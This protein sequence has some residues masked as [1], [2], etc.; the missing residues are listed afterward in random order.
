MRYSKEELEQW[1]KVES[2]FMAD[3]LLSTSRLDTFLKKQIQ[4][5]GSSKMPEEDQLY[6]LGSILKRARGIHAQDAF[7]KMYSE[8]RINRPYL[9]ELIRDIAEVEPHTIDHWLRPL[10][11]NNR[12]TLKL[13]ILS[14]FNQYVKPEALPN[15]VCPVLLEKPKSLYK[16]F[17]AR[18]DEYDDLLRTAKTLKE[19][20]PKYN[21]LSDSIIRSV[22]F[23]CYDYGNRDY[24][25]TS[26][27]N[28]IMMFDLSIEHDISIN[29]KQ[30]LTDLHK[31]YKPEYVYPDALAYPIHV[32]SKENVTEKELKL[33]FDI[34][35]FILEV[36][37]NTTNESQLYR[38]GLAALYGLMQD[39][40]QY[41]KYITEIERCLHLQMKDKA[42]GL[43]NLKSI[44]DNAPSLE[45]A[46]LDTYQ[47]YVG[48]VHNIKLIN[49]V[50]YCQQP[51]APG[52]E[53]YGSLVYTGYNEHAPALVKAY[54]QPA[55]YIHALDHNVQTLYI[56]HKEY[57]DSLLS[58]LTTT[59][60]A[61]A[62]EPWSSDVFSLLKQSKAL[63]KLTLLFLCAGVTGTM[64]QFES[65]REGV[66]PNI[67]WRPLPFLRTMYPEHLDAWND[68][69]QEIMSVD[70]PTSSD[71]KKAYA[72]MFDYLAP[73]LLSNPPP[74]TQLINISE[75]L[76]LPIAEYV[77][78]LC[79]TQD[80]KEA[81]DFQ[82]RPL[83]V[84]F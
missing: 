7:Q 84:D 43:T 30:M 72:Q 44:H 17:V 10:I 34:L 63:S 32:L 21:A 4:F 78:H 13:L 35:D 81:L 54:V 53:D 37:D 38:P 18:P 23:E 64:A 48:D 56:E 71:F 77:M 45:T 5:Y 47:K 24:K 62:M 69:V 79:D 20:D 39:K 11:D 33:G 15:Y 41:K 75:S 46:L 52:Y 3:G 83:T 73:K 60:E 27:F 70:E 40:P 2:F 1:Q 76:G 59:M 36:H 65:I 12:P 26:K 50:Y 25:F 9:K 31:Y 28:P 58:S 42:H 80:V 51:S 22:L 19:L 82:S 68:V 16:N 49:V 6:L 55:D 29:P 57:A 74:L 67:N 14:D 8:L 66:L 61:I